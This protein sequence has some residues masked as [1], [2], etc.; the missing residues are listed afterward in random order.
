[1][2]ITKAPGCKVRA[3][4][5]VLCAFV[6]SVELE[7]NFGAEMTF[8]IS[9]RD[10]P[11]FKHMFSHLEENKDKLAIARIGVSVTTLEEVFLR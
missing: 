4:L 5:D 8:R 9:R 3:I 7:S 10:Q 6:P 2:V 11:F 1:M